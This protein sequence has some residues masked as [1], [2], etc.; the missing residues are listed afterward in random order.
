MNLC[1]FLDVPEFSQRLSWEF[2]D[3]LRSWT[4][5]KTLCIALRLPVEALTQ[6]WPLHALETHLNKFQFCRTCSEHQDKHLEIKQ[7]ST[8]RNL[9]GSEMR[10]VRNEEA[11]SYAG[12]ALVEV[13][14]ESD[15]APICGLK[16][17]SKTVEMMGFFPISRWS[18]NKTWFLQI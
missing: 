4:N 16:R 14:E 1:M 15:S 2:F 9:H 6:S 13:I 8:L 17:K 3:P 18:G 5:W 11:I 12:A 7:A 10:P